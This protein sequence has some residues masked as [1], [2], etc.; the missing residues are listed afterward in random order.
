MGKKRYFTK[1]NHK[2][3]ILKFMKIIFQKSWEISIEV[4]INFIF[5]FKN[6]EM[7]KL[8]MSKRIQYM[9]DVLIYF[10]SVIFFRIND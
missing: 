10:S 8:H 5:S 6:T 3:Q 4:Q 7:L 1:D 2:V 9:G